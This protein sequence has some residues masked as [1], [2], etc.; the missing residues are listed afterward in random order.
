MFDAGMR[1]FCAQ[2]GHFPDP[3]PPPHTH[4][5][6][7]LWLL[8]LFQK[9]TNFAFYITQ[10]KN[11]NFILIYTYFDGKR[12][13]VELSIDKLFKHPLGGGGGGGVFQPLCTISSIYSLYGCSP[14]T[15]K[16]LLEGFP[17]D[18]FLAPN[19]GGGA[20]FY[21]F[22]FRTK[23]QREREWPKN[24]HTK[25]IKTALDQRRYDNNKKKTVSG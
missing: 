11:Y 25:T 8:L 15:Q 1:W 20:I 16:H 6:T 23:N 3:R 24:T 19:F 12:E 7:H 9:Y 5:H 2:S 21:L 14:Q 18:S 10:K 17:R 4:T 22:L 13:W